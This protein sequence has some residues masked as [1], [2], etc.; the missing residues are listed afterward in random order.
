MGKINWGRIV[1]GGLLAGVVLNVVDWLVYGVWLKGAYDAA[2]QALGRPNA[3]GGGVI[4]WFVFLDFVY[5]F[6]LLWLYAAIRPR[7]GP[8]LGT[9]V[10]AGVA[11]W[12]LV[13]LLHGLGEAPMG[14][15]PD[16][17]YLFGIIVALFQLPIATVVGAALYQETSPGT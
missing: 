2:L 6:V 1:L 11:V 8:G 3:M 13:S 14:L 10:V 7:F 5:G 16:R 9:A 4:V 12:V 17:L 15:F